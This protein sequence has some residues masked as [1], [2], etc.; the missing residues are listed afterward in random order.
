MKKI[1][2]NMDEIQVDKKETGIIL[3]YL[4]QTLDIEG[5]VVELGCYT[6]DTSIELAKAI[7]STEKRL[8]L[9][10]SFDGLPEKSDQD[11][12]ALGEDF[13]AGELGVSKS[14]LLRRF[15]STGMRLPIIKKDWFS[16]LTP[17]DLPGKISFAFLDGDYYQSIRDSFRLIEDK[18]ADDS[19][20]LIHDYQNDFTPGVRQA[21]DEWLRKNP[22]RKLRIEQTLAIIENQPKAKSSYKFRVTS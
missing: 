22:T 17:N 14:S 10:D 1:Q 13:K 7:K 15:K 12:S 20:I 21:V 4:S 2:I 16:D 19:I 5:D 8:W 11:E 9:Y 3:K 6:G 18:M